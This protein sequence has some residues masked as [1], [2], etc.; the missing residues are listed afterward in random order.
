MSAVSSRYVLILEDDVIPPQGGI[1]QMLAAI[2]S[3]DDCDK[4]AGVGALDRSRLNSGCACATGSGAG[5]Y[6]PWPESEG[7]LA[8]P[9]RVEWA[10]CGC[11]LFRTDQLRRCLPFHCKRTKVGLLGWSGNLFAELR[12]NNEQ[13]FYL[14]PEV[15]AEL[16][17]LA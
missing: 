5:G 1:G 12:H 3:F 10:G 13:C 15:R 4:V 14:L 7:A 8:I 9:L 2:D 11:A 6:V 16:T 17:S